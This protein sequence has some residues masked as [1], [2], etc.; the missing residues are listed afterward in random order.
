MFEIHLFEPGLKMSV[1][2]FKNELKKKF[3]NLKNL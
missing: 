3:L 2:Q 1:T